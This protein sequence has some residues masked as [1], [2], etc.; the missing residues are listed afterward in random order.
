M[1]TPTTSPLTPNRIPRS[2]LQRR[3]RVALYVGLLVSAQGTL[4]F[5]LT[6]FDPPRGTVYRTIDF[7]QGHMHFTPGAWLAGHELRLTPDKLGMMATARKDAIASLADLARCGA[8][9]PVVLV[10]RAPVVQSESGKLV[11]LP[12]DAAPSD[13]TTGLRLRDVLIR[14]KA[15]PSQEKLLVLDVAPPVASA[16]RGHIHHDLGAAIARELDALPDAGRLVL[17]PCAAGQSPHGSPELGQSVFAHYVQEGLR[18]R[19]D[20]YCGSRDGRISVKELAAFVQARVERWTWHNRGEHQKP[21]LLGE[22]SDF[23]IASVDPDAP[24]EARPAAIV[25]EHTGAMQRAWKERDNL[26]Q[27]GQY[28]LTARRFQVHQAWL[29][30]GLSNDGAKVPASNLALPRPSLDRLKLC[31]AMNSTPTAAAE[32]AK[33]AFSEKWRALQQQL[34][35]ARPAD[36]ERIKKR[37]VEQ[38]H[39]A[40]A[41]ADLDAVVFAQ[42]NADPRLDPGSICLFDQ[43]LPPTPRTA[44]ALRLRQLADLATRVEVQAWPRDVIE[45]FLRCT[46]LGEKAQRQFPHMPG[47]LDRLDEA[48]QARHDGEVHLLTRGYSSAED[49]KQSLTAASEQFAALIE[50]NER[51]RTCEKALDEAMADLPWYFEALEAMPELRDG[52]IGAAHAA[53]ELAATLEEMPSGDGW[54]LLNLQSA[55]T[56][57]ADACVTQIQ[58][59]LKMLHEPFDKDALAQLDQQCR[60]ADADART[61]RRAEAILS[62]AGPILPTSQRATLSKSAQALSRRLNDE[63]L[64]QDRHDNESQRPTP[65]AENRKLADDDEAQRAEWRARCNIALLELAGV[66][67]EQLLPLRQKHEHCQ[68]DVND[69][70]P[71]CELGVR[72]KQVMSK[73]MPALYDQ[74]KSWRR[75]ERLAW[76]MSP[77]QNTGADRAEVSPTAEQ[78]LA[79]QEQRGRKLAEQQLYLTRAFHSLN[80]ESAG[81]VAARRFYAQASAK[82][83]AKPQQQ[84]R[85]AL[86]SPVEPLTQKQPYAQVWL[87]VTRQVPAGAI[88][89]LELRVHRPDDAWLEIAAESATLPA[90]PNSKEPRTQTQKVPLKVTRQPDAERTGLQPPLG[91]LIEARCDGKSWHHLVTTPIVPNTQLVQILVSADPDE[92]TATLN[93]IRIRPGKVKQPHYFYVRNLTNRRQKVHV[94]VKAG[95]ALLHRSRKPLLVDADGVHKILFDEAAVPITSVRGPLTVRVLDLDRQKVLHAKSMRVEM[96]PAAEYVKVAEATYDPGSGGNNRWAVQVQAARPVAGPAI[97]AQLVLPMQRIPGLLGVGGGTLRA[98]VPAQAE[99]PRVL[100]AEN[101]RLIHAGQ[102]EGPVYLHIDGVPRAFVYQTTFSHAGEPIQARH[103]E[104]PAVRIA[105]PACVMAGVNCLVDVEVDNSP[106]GTKLEVALGRASKDGGFKPE[107][108]REFTDAKKC[109][110]EVEG[111]KDALVFNGSISDWTA[112]FDTRSIVGARELQARLID[113]AGKVIAQS[114]QPIVI[115]DSPPIARIVPT[116]A[117]VKR[118]SVLQVQAEG[119][120]PESGI[121]QVVFFFGQPDKGEAPPGAPRFKAIPASRDRSFWMAALLIPADHKGPL[122]ISVQVV[123]HAGLA[124]TDTVTLEVT[125]ND[126]GKTGLGEIRGKVTEGPRPQPNLL[127]TLLDERGKEIARTRTQAD[128]TYSFGQLAPGRYRVIAVKPESQ[129]RAVLDV[130]VEPDRPVRADLPLAL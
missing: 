37:F 120:D 32:N 66:A 56:L 90:L 22:A 11:L 16:W 53:A 29:Q 91:F 104:S 130:S 68:K 129:R 115:D 69:P 58:V 9:Q 86:T 114:R 65:L 17:C 54:W 43:L 67:D 8:S 46:E 92:P 73:D 80:F 2:N 78:R 34:A 41:D 25:R 88:G 47:Y 36:V 110:I 97:A 85:F 30:F 35:D 49:A 79:D 52:W 5:L 101:I 89:P 59:A 111:A 107:L 44:E 50:I 96:L 99:T 27:T 106:P 93:D 103:D 72:F 24:L 123:N 70:L 108:V 63:I 7:S 60:A 28:R 45:A 94:E 109:R 31:G 81:I 10:V 55:Q 61:L 84:V 127:V 3:L 100:F 20:G 40:A 105:A 121:A 113:A 116:P 62:V 128:G 126:P 83:A 71:W 48:M 122:A 33:K 21:S 87:E 1:D 42:A 77:W 76:L 23:A 12:S 118:G 124:S 51:W 38:M 13:L 82:D 64:A 57:Q 39:G 74:E 18:G 98:D 112:T 117:Q 95:E 14:L 26:Y 75:R 4:A 6:W 119:A 125:E 102:Q 15:C 19:A